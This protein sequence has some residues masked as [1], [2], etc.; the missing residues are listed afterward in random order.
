MKQ[1][2]QFKSQLMQASRTGPGQTAAATVAA[3][4]AFLIIPFASMSVIL[5]MHEMFKV[6]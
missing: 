2:S 1:L 6:A 4:S 5:V 3:V